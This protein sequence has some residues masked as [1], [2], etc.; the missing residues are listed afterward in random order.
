VYKDD[1][2][3]D[4]AFITE[5]TKLA[6]QVMADNNIFA[7]HHYDVTSALPLANKDGNLTI[8]GQAFAQQYDA[9]I[10]K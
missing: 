10:R 1:K 6:I 4:T 3:T 8:Q 9:L 5:W 7:S 2:H